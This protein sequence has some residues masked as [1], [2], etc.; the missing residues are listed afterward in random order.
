ML[1][2]TIF[3]GGGGGISVGVGVSSISSF[4]ILSFFDFGTSILGQG[5]SVKG[6]LLS[7]GV[8]VV[9]L[10]LI[11]GRGASIGGAGGA[12]GVKGRCFRGIFKLQYFLFRNVKGAMVQ[13]RICR[14]K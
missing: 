11:R 5:V 14:A 8:L 2:E 1:Q 9:R 13:G 3:T 6:I 12:R 7:L 10:S 4:P